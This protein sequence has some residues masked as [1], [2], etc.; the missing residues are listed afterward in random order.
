MAQFSGFKAPTTAFIQ[1]LSTNNDKSWF[2]AHR[3]EYETHYIEPAKTFVAALQQ[4]L[5]HLVPSIQ[6]VPKVN[7]SIFRINRDTRFS[8]D[9]RPYKDHLDL[10]FWEGERKGAVSGLFFRLT[11]DRLILGAGAHMFDKARLANYRSALADPVHSTAL[12]EVQEA[13]HQTGHQLMGSHYVK[14]PRG[15]VLHHKALEPLSRHNALYAQVESPHPGT[16]G[17]PAFIKTCL[18]TWAAFVP[19]HNWLVRMA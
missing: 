6:A 1:A 19:L 11:A 3:A 16:L 7:G 8:K 18:S 2:D 15:L 10:W 13:L 4:P 9:K 14:T 12:L 17:T 5:Q